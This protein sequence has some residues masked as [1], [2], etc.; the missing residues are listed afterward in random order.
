MAGLGGTIIAPTP[1]VN[2]NAITTEKHLQ[3][4]SLVISLFLQLR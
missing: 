3:P 2:I 4:L 1:K